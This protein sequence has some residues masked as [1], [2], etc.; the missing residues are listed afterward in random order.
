MIDDTKSFLS[1]ADVELTN[2]AGDD[3]ATI[4]ETDDICIGLLVIARKSLGDSS[5]VSIVFVIV[6]KDDLPG[7]SADFC[8]EVEG[9]SID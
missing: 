9:A 6:L 5:D 2:G 1:M 3:D 4:I 7:G 8:P